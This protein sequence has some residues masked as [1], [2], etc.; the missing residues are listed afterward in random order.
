MSN[1]SL[2]SQSPRVYFAGAGISANA[3]TGFP[4]ARD[5]VSEILRAIAPDKSTL[6]LLETVSDSTRLNKR[7]PGDYLRFE[8]LLDIIQQLVDPE[9]TILE[10]ISLFASP[11][12]VHEFLATR[13]IAGDIVITTNFDCLIEASIV[14]LGSKPIS[15]C[16]TGDFESWTTSPPN[17]IPIYKIHGSYSR[18]D[19]T[20]QTSSVNT[21]QA[22]LSTLT[23]GAKDLLLPEAKRKFLIQV[24]RSRT[25]IVCGY[26]GG[27]DLDI[28]PTFK[29][30]SPQSL[31]WLVHSRTHQEPHEITEEWRRTLER[32]GGDSLS[33]RDGFMR[34]K[35]LEGEYPLRIYE[36]NTPRYFL[37][38]DNV[39]R[40]FESRT[41][42]EADLRLRTFIEEWA[43]ALLV[44][45]Y[46]K[47]LVSG[48]ILF[49]LARFQESYELYAKAWTLLDEYSEPSESADV[50]R[51]I[52]RIAVEISRFKE[53]EEWSQKSD[54]LSTPGSSL[55]AKS[56]QQH[57]FAYYKL[58]RF[59]EALQCF[60]EAADICRHLGL[61]R[62][63]AYVL[64]D[65]ALIYQEM[66]QFRKAISLYQE[67]IELSAKDG[68]IRHVMFS[69]HQLGTASFD[70]GE[71]TKS[72]L[73]HSKAL[74]LARV[75]GD[76]AQIENSEHEL[77]MLDFMGGKVLESIRRFRRGIAMAEE[78]GRSQYVGMDLQHIGIA[79][80]EVGKLHM[81]KRALLA[82]KEQYL[83]I[84]D[85]I[86]LSELQAYMCQYFLVCGD[87]ESAL[88]AAEEGNAL[89]SKF[90]AEEFQTRTAFMIGLTTWLR[91]DMRSGIRK[92]SEVVELAH[93]KEFKALLLDQLYLCA[94]HDVT[95]LTCDRLTAFM[96]WGISTY[97]KLG[98]KRRQLALQ[99]L[100]TTCVRAAK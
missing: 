68:D 54:H 78:T 92:M 94:F 91:G 13:A 53:A 29:I 37:P 65:S 89:A 49:S 14:E 55:R 10:F 21:I 3:P 87:Y 31:N 66:S 11:N 42:S 83:A 97:E 96:E 84:N 36:V 6:E 100:L 8:L 75:L 62:F 32:G 64:H 34:Q 15:I 98:N 38:A 45:P 79:L 7:N 33:T 17:R 58:E 72:N 57:G 20:A 27:D 28:V 85:H 93:A 50:A 71:F 69:Y 76:H 40:G 23:I 82:A 73:Y 47:F 24:T 16:T 59:S 80:M 60:Q 99:E 88:A 26:S 1:I 67:S 19:G 2:T 30:L 70:L 56:L 90:R 5:L 61:D 86:T 77:G 81:A 51:M 46:L 63:L 43:R 22:T 74:E 44:K 95:G 52:S 18:Y 48:H 35:F 39:N 4:L 9:L 12:R 25:M 41:S